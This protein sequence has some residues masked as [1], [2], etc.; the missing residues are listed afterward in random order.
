MAKIATP[1]TPT[2]GVGTTLTPEF[3]H[4]TNNKS[5]PGSR[6]GNCRDKNESGYCLRKYV[7]ACTDARYPWFARDCQK[8]CGKCPGGGGKL[9]SCIPVMASTGVRCIQSG[10]SGERLGWVELDLGCSTILLGQ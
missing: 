4:Q 5:I 10:A 8:L 1:A 2:P 7:R 9:V 3:N 6:S